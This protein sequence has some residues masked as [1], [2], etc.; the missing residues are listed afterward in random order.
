MCAL[1]WSLH[2]R[3]QSPLG[4][5]LRDFRK[6]SSITAFH[7]KR[8]CSSWTQLG[9]FGSKS[10]FFDLEQRQYKNYSTEFRCVLI[11]NL[12]P[13]FPHRIA[14]WKS[15][16]N[17]KQTFIWSPSIRSYIILALGTDFFSGKYAFLQIS[18]DFVTEFEKFFFS[19]KLFRQGYKKM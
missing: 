5:Q 14:E 6:A 9:A 12:P 2:G 1:S 16:P 3:L 4:L 8:G 15:A 11:L 18:A 7:Y 17:S 19:W 13:C 10:L